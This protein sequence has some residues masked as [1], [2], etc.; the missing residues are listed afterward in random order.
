MYTL[1]VYVCVYIYIYVCVCV[2]VCVC[3]LH[4]V[5]SWRILL[6]FMR[7]F[8]GPTGCF[9][10][11]SATAGLIHVLSSDLDALKGYSSCCWRVACLGF[12][13]LRYMHLRQH[14]VVDGLY[15]VAKRLLFSE[16]PS[17]AVSELFHRLVCGSSRNNLEAMVV[18][19]HC[20]LCLWASRCR[21]KE[22]AGPLQWSYTVIGVSFHFLSLQTE[23]F[24]DEMLQLVS[25]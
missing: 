12:F 11:N 19:T 8:K 1:Y 7:F 18:L 2:C 13:C 14:S 3:I 10:V 22:A 9:M 4:L 15:V 23:A 17:H 25:N 6:G 20:V 16:G 21:L 5:K 24:Q